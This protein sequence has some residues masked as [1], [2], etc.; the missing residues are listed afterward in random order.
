MARDSCV[1]LIFTTKVDPTLG[2]T[3]F[4]LILFE[5]S[6][7]EFVLKFGNTLET[8][9]VTLLRLSPGSPPPPPANSFVIGPA[10][11]NTHGYQSTK[12][13]TAWQPEIGENGYARKIVH[14]SDP[15]PDILSPWRPSGNCH[16]EKTCE[17]FIPYGM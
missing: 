8:P 5:K 4:K 1:F 10:V 16:Q 7:L 13:P 2:S 6:R 3:F 17:K 15:R 9:L 14:H 12:V 11:I